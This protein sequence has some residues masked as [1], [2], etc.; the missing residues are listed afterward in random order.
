MASKLRAGDTVPLTG[1]VYTAR[2]AAHKKSSRHGCGRSAP[3][4]VRGSG[5]LHGANTRPEAGAGDRFR[6]DRRQAVWIPFAPR[7]LD[8]GLSCM[9]GKGIR[10]K[11]CRMRWRATE[12]CIWS[13]SAA[14]RGQGGVY[15]RGWK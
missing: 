11:Q 4:C 3:V 9:I 14:G 7:L 8:A 1:T 2:D 12:R 6:S 5:N 10:C 15:Q 13:R